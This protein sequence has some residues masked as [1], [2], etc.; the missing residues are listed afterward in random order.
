MALK[1][2]K[3][4]EYIGVIILI[5]MFIGTGIYYFTGHELTLF[6]SIGMLF[7]IFG[8]Y[9]AFTLQEEWEQDITTPK[10]FKRQWHYTNRI[11]GSIGIIAIILF[12]FGFP[13][14]LI[15]G[16]SI[17]AVTSIFIF[18]G[19][20]LSLPILLGYFAIRKR[21]VMKED[22]ESVKPM[23]I[24]IVMIL[25]LS[26][27]ARSQIGLTGAITTFVIAIVVIGSVSFWRK[28][29]K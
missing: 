13:I 9:L 6:I 2:K 4:L 25:L 3:F 10:G 7:F 15:T 18:L 8:L 22:I 17:L 24:P 27:L 29:R 16:N 12:S 14:A 21:E 26:A 1:I 28:Y 5:L 23:I 11:F 20:L 19:F